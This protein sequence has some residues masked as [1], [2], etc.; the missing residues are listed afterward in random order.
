MNRI[1]VADPDREKRIRERCNVLFDFRDLF[2][3]CNFS[4]LR[5]FLAIAILLVMPGLAS[6]QDNIVRP[7]ITDRIDET[8]LTALQGNTHPLARAQFDQGAAQPNLPMD[9]MLLVLKRS[10]EQEAALQ[11]L[12]EQQQ[13]KASPNYHKWLTPDQFGQQFGPADQDIQGVTSWL[14]SQGFQS[15]QVSKGRTVIEFSGT[16]AQVESVLHA[17][18]HKYAVNGE[19]HWANA[20][21]PQ[22]PAALVPVVAGVATLHNFLKEPY[23]V[24][25]GETFAITSAQGER[26][27][28]RSST[29]NNALGPA[30][31][32]V[33]YNIGA[34]MTGAGA[35]I[36]VVGR[37]NI[38]VQDIRDFRNRFGLAANDPQV[39]LNGPDP[40][41]LGGG[42]ETEAVLDVSWSGAVAPNATIKFVVSEST[43]AADGVDLSEIYIIDNNLADV[44]T[45]S[46]GSCEGFVSSGTASAIATLAQQAAAQ[47]ITF[48]VSSG[49]N[50]AAG[51]DDQNFAPATHA[52]SVNV[53]A[54]SPFTVA[55]GGT[56]FNE[57]G[58]SSAYWNTTNGP[59]FKTA[60]S[61]I[62]EN[63]WNE[64]GSVTGGTGLWSSSGG[65]SIFF[66][67]KPSW[68]S[69]VAGIPTDGAR[70]LP[71]VS[72]SAAAH[73]PY[74][75][76]LR[77]SC[78]GGSPSFSGISG[79]SASVQAF[80]GIMAL[81]VEKT[82][83]RQ[84]Q[85]NYVLY[86]L[87]A[88]ETLS[89]CNGSATPGPPP[90]P[91]NFYDTTV[92]NN[93]VPGLTGFNAG[94]GYDLA[95]GLGSVN[96]SNLVNN[97][98][99]VTF[100]GSTTMLSLNGGNPVTITH[101]ASVPVS[102]TVAAKSPATGTPTG[103]VSLIA[104]TSANQGVDRF[105]LTTVGLNGS[106]SSTTTAL[107]G[108]SYAVEA[109][110]AGDSNFGASD[111]IPVSVTVNTESSKTG[112]GIVTFSPTGTIL[113]TN[114]TS[115][116][117]GS[118]YILSVAVTNSAG[119]VCNP[120]GPACPTGTVTLTDNGVALDGGSF[121]LNSLGFL[122]DQ[123][124][125]LPAGTHNILAVYGGD[126]SFSGST[127]TTDVVNVSKAT[128]TTAV[129]SN[130]STAASG[131][132]VPLTATI[133]TSSNATASLQQEPTG[134]VQFFVGGTAF[135][136]PVAVVGGVNS[137][138]GFAQATASFAPTTLP[139]GTDSITA[140][141][142]GDSN[143]STSTSSAVVVAVG[144]SFSISFNPTTVNVTSP[145]QSGTTTVTITGQTG[146]NG[147][148][149]FTSSSCSAGL[150]SL[151][152]CSFNPTSITGSGTSVLTISTTATKTSFAIP[153][154]RLHWLMA[155]A[156]AT[157]A[158]FFTMLVVF[159]QRRRVFRLAGALAFACV[160]FAC[161][162]C[163]KPGGPTT[164][165]GTPTGTS[166]VT[167]TATG[168]GFTNS[169]TFT[170]NV[171]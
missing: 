111:S 6:A 7:R 59:G 42:E 43:N 61:Y 123:P 72:L 132:P 103:D 133:A 12:L 26:L 16:A 161:A 1:V 150:P 140:Q 36:A 169:T 78:A 166:T 47:G 101:G 84:G 58:N 89:S 54:S 99:S 17:A 151:T 149:N 157:F 136:S 102:I 91:C 162:G 139:N 148:I 46:F 8:R 147:T 62:P 49:D 14:T 29:G 27:Q 90:G 52:A 2:G 124:I 98:G 70:D 69:G 95:T 79:T 144:P 86:K 128:T 97:W 156:A 83:A 22:I 120:G 116:T 65:K 129:S 126:N 143:Y 158:S 18:I 170:L 45:E 137:T 13:S 109:H 115:L 155:G 51:C 31:F 100:K 81:V 134:T 21:D 24:R 39:I 38:N 165:P 141:Y 30:D 118:P 142:A 108:G 56:Q 153:Q 171:Q 76:C 113:S 145:G 77:G 53:L 80:G 164:T 4:R 68:Q 121:K 112:L 135:G 25:S 127:S 44:M 159:S 125:Q 138:T 3:I 94:V 75:V 154:S 167:V 19:D 160:M 73:D 71:D 105:T 67:P 92:G 114:A 82:L 34:T 96:V 163:T 88:S 107:P 130:V 15:I 168:G 131:S 9:R 104:S 33:I 35:N 93:T 85:A 110:Y 60:I 5:T 66:T 40:G 20:N 10:P 106:I 11:D 50:G 119:S 41:N 28:F 87:A 146:Y 32:G 57:N 55:V 63:V 152:T 48:L 37:T 74:L 117:Y 23:S 122:E 64:S